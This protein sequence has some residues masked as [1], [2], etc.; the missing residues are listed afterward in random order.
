[1]PRW[2]I[3]FALVLVLVESSDVGAAKPQAS[4]GAPAPASASPRAAEVA[5]PADGDYSIDLSVDRRSML[6]VSGRRLTILGADG[7][8]RSRSADLAKPYR[9]LLDR[10]TYF[11]ALT[12]TTLEL[13]DKSTLVPTR[14]IKLNCKDA[15]DVAVHPTRRVAFVTLSDDEP[16]GLPRLGAAKIALVDLATFIVTRPPGL[17]GRWLAIDSDG[18]RL[19]A[20]ANGFSDLITAEELSLGDAAKS[21]TPLDVL[22]AY[23]LD[24]TGATVQSS[25]VNPR[26]GASGRAVRIAPG[27]DVVTY[28]S[29]G[30]TPPLSYT[31][32]AFDAEDVGRVVAEYALKDAA[33][34]AD[35]AY[36]PVLPIVAACGEKGVMLFDAPSGKRI[37]GRL[38]VKAANVP[39]DPKRVFWSPDGQS[40][41]IDVASAGGSRVLRAY[42]LKLTP[43]EINA[44][45]RP[46]PAR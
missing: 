25:R 2:L 24:E 29:A 40:L 32:P 11:V 45:R 44:L 31:L 30:G 39:M 5:L 12:P 46:P 36:H 21:D 6:L 15:F 37:E 8:T 42:E 1:V 38:V 34:C 23:T 17:Y 14:T 28:V 41:L 18:R 3:F 13:V 10:E 20:G 16:G 33:P 26:A 22:L 7:R 27:G 4:A 43:A 9:R 35:L 19:F